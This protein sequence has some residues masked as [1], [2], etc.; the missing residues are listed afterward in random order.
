VRLLDVPRE[1]VDALS[2]GVLGDDHGC[3]LPVSAALSCWSGAGRL[4][5]GTIDEDA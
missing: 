5:I 3:V 2:D 4:N 1:R